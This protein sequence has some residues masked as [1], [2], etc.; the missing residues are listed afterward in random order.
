MSVYY[1]LDHQRVQHS[2]PRLKIGPVN[3]TEDR[4][5]SDALGSNGESSTF[6]EIED[7]ESDRGY[8]SLEAERSRHGGEL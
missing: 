1:L 3:T 2:T 4:P 8:R 7:R 5:G 6:E